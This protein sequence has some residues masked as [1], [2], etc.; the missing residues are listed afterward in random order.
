MPVNDLLRRRERAVAAAPDEAHQPPE[1]WHMHRNFLPTSISFARTQVGLTCQVT[2]YGE[3]IHWRV[4]A[5]IE[6]VDQAGPWSVPIMA[7]G[8]APTREQAAQEAV[9]IADR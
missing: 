3:T 5:A 1:G 2:D 7:T 9:R 8:M 4:F 6:G